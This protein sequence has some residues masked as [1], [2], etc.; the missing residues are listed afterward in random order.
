[1]S[2]P[3][4]RSLDLRNILIRPSAKKTYIRPFACR[5]RASPTPQS[6]PHFGHASARTQGAHSARRWA[7]ATTDLLPP[8]R[9]WSS[10]ASFEFSERGVVSEAQIQANFEGRA[11]TRDASASLDDAMFQNGRVFP[12]ALCAGFT[13]PLPTREPSQTTAAP[14]EPLERNL[15]ERPGET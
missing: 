12:S 13:L 1:M 6:K 3:R 4:L 14:T 7:W 10:K 11:K 5:S 9:V 2:L 15:T 8:V